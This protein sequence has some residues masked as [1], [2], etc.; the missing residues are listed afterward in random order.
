M[1]GRGVRPAL[2][3]IESTLIA[4][5]GLP[6]YGHG[7]WNDSLQPV[8][9]ELA[10][11]LCSTWTVI[12]QTHALSALAA[13][14]RRPSTELGTP[15]ALAERAQDLADRGLADLRRLLLVDGVLAGYGLFPDDG[16]PVEPL[17]HPRDTRTG[18]RYSLL[19]MIHAIA[20][21]LL[22]PAEA[23]HHLDLIAEHLC[24]PDGARLFDRP[25][26]YAGGPMRL[27]QRAEASTFFG[28]EIGLMYMH[29]H[30]RYAEALARVGDG[31]GLLQALAL[32][33]PIGMTDRVPLGPAAAVDL[34]LLLLR[35]RVPG[36][37]R[38]GRGLRRDRRR[39][40]PARGRLAGLLVR[41]GSVRPAAGPAPARAAGP[42]RRGGDRPGAR[43]GPRRPGRCGSRCS[44]AGVRSGSRSVRSGTGWSAVR[45][46]TTV[47]GTNPLANPYRDGGVSIPAEDLRSLA[48][49]ALV[50]IETR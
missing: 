26:G 27:F 7:D 37:L 21:D 13:E 47:L 48:E 44:G 10:A 3:H 5:T 6:A 40:R 15:S 49:E 41:A 36:P 25:V 39:D 9:P 2:D 4:G 24:G 20:D 50:E 42:R 23:R 11:R 8:D 43:P 12:L 34:L 17:I 1:T 14:L 31:P 30:L 46:G 28:R 19:P 22:T 29:A 18:L 32:A 45:V 38:R 33:Q 35:R 16:G